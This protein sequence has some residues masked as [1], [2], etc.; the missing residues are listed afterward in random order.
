[1]DPFAHKPWQA[2]S[3]IVS[4]KPIDRSIDL[5]SSSSSSSSNMPI[6][7][8]SQDE[9]TMANDASTEASPPSSQP[10]ESVASFASA[11]DQAS[12]YDDAPPLA[13][14]S[15]RQRPA[16]SQEDEF[17][18]IFASLPPPRH[19]I[20][21]PTITADKLYAVLM[22]VNAIMEDDMM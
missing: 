18:R 4:H 17:K 15:K 13:G 20:F 8:K 2:K 9:S 11:S 3:T 19:D 21:Q 14:P 7:R 12:D 1:V 16:A 6:K 10:D 5:A 22:E